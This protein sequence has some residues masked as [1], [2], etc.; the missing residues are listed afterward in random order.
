MTFLRWNDLLK[1]QLQH[2]VGGNTL[3]GILQELVGTLNQYL[4][5]F[6]HKPGS[7]GPEIKRWKWVWPLSLLPAVIHYKIFTS[8]PFSLSPHVLA[9]ASRGTREGSCQSQL[10]H[11]CYHLPHPLQPGR[12]TCLDCWLRGACAPILTPAPSCLGGLLHQSSLRG[13]R[14]PVATMA[15]YHLGG[16]L[17]SITA[18][19]PSCLRCSCVQATSEADSSGRNTCRGRAKTTADPQEPMT[20][21]E[22]LKPL[23][24]TVWIMELHFCW[25]L[26]KFSDCETSKR[27]SA[28]AARTAL[29][30]AAVGF[31]GTYTWGL[32]NVRVWTA[33]IAPTVGR[34]AW[35]LQSWDLA[36]VDLHWWPGENNTWES[37]GPISGIP[38]VKEGPRAV[39]TTVYIVSPNNQ[40]KETQQN[41]F[42]G[43]QLQKRNTQWLLSHWECLNNV[44]LVLWI[45]NSAKK[46][47]W[48]LYSNN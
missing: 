5:C 18:S 32:G 14:V 11:P 30:L 19:P 2:Q 4:G 33:S 22:E 1:T 27:T 34:G 45:R 43:E 13:S 25:W 10:T 47:I 48:G 38:T 9:P 31:V 24:A 46:Q 35:L 8:H 41:T 39:P 44:F 23:L 29:T 3:Q 7:M 40:W 21:K 36:S 6:F 28:P 37:S 26:H 42:T 16:L 17:P 12:C 15:S 20:K